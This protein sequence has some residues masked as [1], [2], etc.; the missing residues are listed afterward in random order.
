MVAKAKE[1]QGAKH[2]EHTHPEPEYPSEDVYKDPQYPYGGGYSTPEYQYPTEGSYQRP[3]YPDPQYSK[4]GYP[5]PEYPTQGGYPRPYKPYEGYIETPTPEYLKGWI[6]AEIKEYGG[7]KPTTIIRANSDWSICMYWSLHGVLAPLICGE[8]CCH[9]FFESMGPGR[10]F[11]L[12]QSRYINLPQ[13]KQGEIR[14]PLDPCGD[15]KYKYEFQIPKGV[16]RAEHCG[17]PYKLVVSLTYYD[18][19]GRPGP[20][21]G[22]VELP[23]VQF[24]WPGKGKGHTHTNPQS[25]PVPT[26][27]DPFN[28][29]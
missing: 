17:I 22:F 28:L 5:W 13:Y 14:I 23:M 20:M 25:E 19:C 27:E 11:S 1:S 16:V 7:V 26:P 18:Q 12:P 4:P 2:G 15:G 9:V 24:F 21:A 6:A 3:E 10:E 29:P 8:W